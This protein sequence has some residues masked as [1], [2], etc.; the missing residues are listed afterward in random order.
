MTFFR[1]AP[2]VAALLLPA[3]AG[4]AHNGIHI[5]DPYARIIAGSGV[6]YFQIE[7]M[8]ALPDRLTGARTDLG[9]AL[10]M[11]STANADGV[12]QMHAVPESFA[13][14]AGQ[15]RSLS[16][17]ADHIMLSGVTARLKTG[18]SFALTLSFA[19]VG[20]VT[21]TVPVDNARRTDPGAGPTPYDAM[22]A[23]MD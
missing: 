8:K 21:V 2:G 11:N 1:G 6:V 14:E 17:A 12:T 23:C 3:G 13:V 9:M 16:A 20:D 10:L 19:G 15:V 5:H 18:D 22:S 4:F 7:N